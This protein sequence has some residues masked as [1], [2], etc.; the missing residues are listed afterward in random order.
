MTTN[1]VENIDPALLRP[2]GAD[3]HVFLDYATEYQVKSIFRAY[4]PEQMDPFPEFY[5]DLPANL[6]IATLQ[7]FFFM[8]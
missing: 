2:G 1:H 3:R 5:K 8:D 6:T 4:V 7:K